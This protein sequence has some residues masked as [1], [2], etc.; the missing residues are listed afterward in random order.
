LTGTVSEIAVIEGTFGVPQEYTTSFYV[1][2]DYKHVVVSSYAPLVWDVQA[3]RPRVTPFELLLPSSTSG[4]FLGVEIDTRQLVLVDEHFQITKRFDVESPAEHGADLTWSDDERFA[5]C[6]ASDNPSTNH[7]TAFRI[8][9]ETGLQTPIGECNLRD[10]FV[11]VGPAGKLLRL[12]VAAARVWGYFDGEMGT[13][14]A[15]LEPD[16]TRRTL[17]ETGQTRQPRKGQRG[18][19]FPPMIAAPDGSHVAAA[20]PR[21]EDQAP[22]AHYHLIDPTGRARPFLPVS[23]ESYLTPYYPIAFA[24]SGDRLIARSGSTLFSIPVSLVAEDREASDGE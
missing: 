12:R 6:R 20:V 3:S 11:F 18:A 9:L 22:G 8:D 7:A 10:E 14:V 15:V 4:R 21:S 5:V 23:D 17:F 1:T 24:E 2:P 16:G 19:T 13:R